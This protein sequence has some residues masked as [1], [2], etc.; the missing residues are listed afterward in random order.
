MER[1]A[2]TTGSV[3]LHANEFHHLAPLFGFVGDKL[4]KI[5]GREGERGATEIGKARLDLG[6]SKGRIDL[7]V[8]FLDDL[9]RR[10]FWC[11]D[12]VP[13]A[14]LISRHELSE[15]R[16]LWQRFRAHRG[17]YRERTQ[18]AVPDMLD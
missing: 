10:G 17:R 2:E 3:R 1:G 8:E 13:E 5:G 12:A 4:F 14:R 9:G 11:A 18:L 16:N 6:I 7:L 15:S